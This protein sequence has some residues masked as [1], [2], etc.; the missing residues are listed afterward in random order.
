MTPASPPRQREEGHDEV[1]IFVIDESYDRIDEF[2]DLDDYLDELS[3]TD[4]ASAVFRTRIEAEFG[5]SFEQ[6]NVGPGADMP[7]F[8]TAITSNIVPLLPWLLAV[9]FSGK[10]II[11]NL[12]AWQTIYGRMRPYFSRTTITNRNGAAVLAMAAVFEDMGGIPKSVTLRGYT[13]GYRHDEDCVA[14]PPAI[15]EP[16]PTL[17]LSLVNHVFH[18]EADGVAFLVTVDGEKASAKRI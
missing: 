8:V 10:P 17:G 11:D 14:A 12:G 5:S 18:I 6:V 15:E 2:V 4:A 1:L 13:S 3:A 7:A 9:F 16:P